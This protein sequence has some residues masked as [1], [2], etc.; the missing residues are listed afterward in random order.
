MNEPP[1][2]RTELA[3]LIRERRMTYEEFAEHAERFARDNGE[4]GTLSVRHLQRLASGQ[5]ADGT[6][7]GPV[8]PATARL[9]ERVLSVEIGTLLGPPIL[10]GRKSLP[11]LAR[12]LGNA[13]K[14]GPEMITLLRDQVTAL[15]RLDRE[16]GARV[17]HGEAQAKAQQVENLRVHSL[18][19]TVRSELGRLQ[20]ELCT[21]AGW[22]ALDLG[23]LS[24]AWTFYEMG[25]AAAADSGRPLHLAHVWAEQ[26]FILID[27]GLYKEAVAVLEN[28]DT[29]SAPGQLRAWFLAALGEAYAASG[30]VDDSRRAFDAAAQ[31]PL[32]D[33]NPHGPYVALNQTHLARWRGN[34]LART[35]DRDAINT[36]ESAFRNLDTSF[37]RARVSLQTDL[38]QAYLTVGDIPR[39]RHYLKRAAPT[40]EE[41]GSARQ[42][43][44]LNALA[45]RVLDASRR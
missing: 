36:L 32:G 23:L 37:V 24:E 38:A 1:A 28:L 14:I 19:P 12:T 45:P 2:D 33:F 18:T 10:P 8:R 9:L 29:R 4:P 25:K 40:A 39:A 17:A 6:P 13:R 27:L 3:R 7:L 44:R 20:A 26:A 30:Q 5:R 22:Q 16:L 42:S 11:D 31:L 35:G 43:A 34:A 41:I 21:L 15:R